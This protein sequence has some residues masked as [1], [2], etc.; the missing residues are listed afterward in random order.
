[1]RIR[2]RAASVKSARA[3]HVTI[4]RGFLDFEVRAG[5]VVPGFLAFRGCYR[6]RLDDPALPGFARRAE[7]SQH[8]DAKAT[9]DA[10]LNRL[11]EC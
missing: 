4:P 5:Y 6:L 9:A 11:A 2:N 8:P 1:M 7:A 10:I 3:E